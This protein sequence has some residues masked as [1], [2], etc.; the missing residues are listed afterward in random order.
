[1]Y[2]V[3]VL[4]TNASGATSGSL[5]SDFPSVN[6][7]T[8]L[9]IS[10]PTTSMACWADDE[11][12]PMSNSFWM[13]RGKNFVDVPGGVLTGVTEDDEGAGTSRSGGR[14]S[15]GTT[16]LTGRNEITKIIWIIATLCG[17][18]MYIVHVTHTVVQIRHYLH[19]H[20]HV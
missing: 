9:S 19:I 6:R 4:A 10:S 20:V 2:N 7:L 17:I 15:G 1:M 3:H 8:A 13:T 11:E 5:F 18:T 14:L 16:R 12:N